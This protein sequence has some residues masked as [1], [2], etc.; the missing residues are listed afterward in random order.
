M[1]HCL[2]RELTFY[3]CTEDMP[4]RV[5]AHLDWESISESQT[6]SSEALASCPPDLPCGGS[7]SVVE[8]C[9]DK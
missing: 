8:K 9:S 1:Q 2:G 6:P 4:Q 5:L 7:T 3:A